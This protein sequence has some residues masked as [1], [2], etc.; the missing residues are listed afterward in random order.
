M[1]LSALKRC[2]FYSRIR[3]FVTPCSH[4]GTQVKG[5][6]ICYWVDWKCSNLANPNLTIHR[7]LN[8]NSEQNREKYRLPPLMWQPNPTFLFPMINVFISYW[9]IRLTIDKEF[10]LSG[11]ISGAKQVQ[12]VE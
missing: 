2:V 6:T 10:R 4:T 3:L 1:L 12:Y 8:T 5:Q 7:F 9:N 11:F